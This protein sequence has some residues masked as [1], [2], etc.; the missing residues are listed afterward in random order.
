MARAGA[1]EVRPPPGSPAGLRDWRWLARQPAGIRQTM[2]DSWGDRTLPAASEAGQF[3]VAELAGP[4]VLDYFRTLDGDARLTF[5]VDGQ[6]LWRGTL[7][8]AARPEADD[9]PGLIP[10]SLA[11]PLLVPV[12]FGSSLRI[13]CNRNKLPHFLSW[14]S[15][16]AGTPMLVATA[17]PEG[18]YA[19]LLRATAETWSTHEPGSLPRAGM[20]VRDVVE[21]FMLPIN[22]RLTVLELLGSGEVIRLEFLLNPP[23]LGTLRH[24][25]A[26]FTYDGAPAPSLRLPLAD[27]VG[28]PHPWLH[29]RWHGR[30]GNRV[31]GILH[32]RDVRPPD[33]ARYSIPHLTLYSNL[34][35]PFAEGMRIDLVNRSGDLYAAGQVRALVMPL[36]DDDAR[37]AGRLCG[38]RTLLPLGAGAEPAPLLR[39]PG[40]G[41]LVGLGLFMTGNRA[42]HPPAA[43][44][45]RISLAL[46]GA[47]PVEGRGLLAPWSVTF[48][49]RGHFWTHPRLE[50]N[51]IGVMRHFVTDPFAFDREAVFAFSLGPDAADAPTQAVALA[52][53]YRFGPTP[54][55]APA[56]AEQAE[57]LPHSVYPLPPQRLGP[58]NAVAELYRSIEAEDLAPLALTHG[59]GARA[60]EDV[61]HHYHPSGGGYLH[62][63][64]ERVKGFVDC[65]IRLPPSRYLAVGANPL[66]GPTSGYFSLGLLAADDPGALRNRSRGVAGG[67]RIE[68][69]RQP[70][71]V[72]GRAPWMRRD[73]FAEW[74]VL[75]NPAPDDWGVL[76]LVCDSI[77]SGPRGDHLRVDQVH[78]LM[79]PP[80]APGWREWEESP[81][82][83]TGGGLTVELAREGRFT[84]SG[85]GAI[86]L[87][88]PPGGTAVFRLLDLCGPDRPVTI[89]LRGNLGPNQGGWR[90]RADD[91]DWVPLASGKDAT[92]VVDWT[93]PLAAAERAQQ[94]RL[95]IACTD[96][97]DR[98]AEAGREPLARLFLDAWT[99]E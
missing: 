18:E 51:F 37:Q 45:H 27:L 69:G 93:I 85:W 83:E 96:I 36:A 46:D 87:T 53:W 88:S 6:L 66:T 82:P 84:W 68:P 97:G 30:S 50:H 77:R 5:L 11:W 20:P 95:E 91:A 41:H 40:P 60:V 21:D 42:V 58:D 38:T 10:P 3:V 35:I 16:A 9:R 25:V 12:G 14:R 13:L 55:A 92:S 56:L 2:G 8:R 39:L 61:E 80:T 33:G 48:P 44:G 4:G 74:A 73:P 29:D 59:C 64:A 79:P 49:S 28:L 63:Q 70:G 76:R 86:E 57:T 65:L 98:Q 19:G 7:A 75:L 31:A 1:G 62:L 15:I 81:V 24:V 72:L 43:R 78:L 67:A 17:D 71:R 54:Y 52:F 47:E 90:V 94:V 32:P 89:R 26:E 22:G 99:M 23:L 34:P